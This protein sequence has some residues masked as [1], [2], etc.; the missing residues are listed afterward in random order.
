MSRMEDD[1]VDYS[2]TSPPYN[3]GYNNMHGKDVRKYKKY[4]DKM[5]PEDYSEWLYRCLDEMIRLS[6]LHVFF[7][8]QMLGGN[9]VNVLEIMGDYSDK[10]KDIIIWN[11]N[12]APPHI[13]PGIMNSKFEFIIILSSDKPHQKKFRDGN[14]RG[15]FNNVIEGS[16]ASRNPY[17]KV[18]KATFPEYL[19]RLMMNKFGKEGD[20][21]FDPFMGTGTTAVAA[22]IEKRRWVGSEIYN[23]YYDIA[24][25]RI[26]EVERQG[27][28]F[29]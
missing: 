23:E 18:H 22:T 3:I 19:P 24:I 9:K 25:E 14:F 10:I 1:C 5:R 12:V 4:N 21:W 11:K 17:A 7:N 6:K 16:N 29:A 13:E 27:N 26:E 8:I 15:N 2:I 20:I 28:L